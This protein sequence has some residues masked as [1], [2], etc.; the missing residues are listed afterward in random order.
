MGLNCC[1]PTLIREK[2]QQEQEKR[3]PTPVRSG[4][5]AGS[6]DAARSWGGPGWGALKPSIWS[7]LWDGDRA[8][9]AQVSL[10]TQR[11]PVS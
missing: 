6:A 10:C 9:H 7:C 8:T 4:P 11:L 3:V 1:R 2:Q 5:W